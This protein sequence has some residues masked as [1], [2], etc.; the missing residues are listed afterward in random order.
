MARYTIYKCVRT[1][2]GWRCCKAAYHPNGKIKPN[3]VIT[4]GVEEKHPEENIS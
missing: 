3:I 2:R 1:D 4:G